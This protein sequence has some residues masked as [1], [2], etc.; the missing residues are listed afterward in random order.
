MRVA[1]IGAGITGLTAANRLKEYAEVKVFEACDVGGLA[2]SIKVNGYWIEKFYHHCFRFDDLLLEEI[3][4]LGLKSKLVWKTARTGFE[5]DGRIYPVNTP[6]EILRFPLLSFTEKLKLTFFTLRSRRRRY[7]EYDDVTAVEGLKSDLGDGITRK[8][9]MPLLR[10]KFGENADRVSYAWLLARVAIRSNRKSSGEEIGYI[11]GGFWQMIDRMKSDIDIALEAAKIGKAGGGWEVNGERFDAVV[12]TAPPPTLGELADILGIPEIP[13]QSSVCL[14]LASDDSITEDIYWTNVTSNLSFG[15][16]IEHT[17]FM[18]FEDYGENL[19][20]LASYSTPDGWLYRM[21]NED[22]KKLFLSELRRIADIDVKWARVFK[23]RFSGPIYVRG[24]A[25]LVTPYRI[26]DGFYLS[27][28]T[29]KPNYPERSMNGSIKA[30]IEVAKC[31]L[32]D[33]GF[34]SSDS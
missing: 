7:E 14:L 17:N 21:G 31:V 8:F 29:S 5:I 16:M 26:S 2:G 34:D 22:I 28:M 25:K 4:R 13:F 27:G 6:I 20:Y 12:Y 15:A 10:S 24:Y 32:D 3:K 18:P 1:V 23:A 19:I 9:F 30:G 11:R 33:Y